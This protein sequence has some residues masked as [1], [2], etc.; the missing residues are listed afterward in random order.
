MMGSNKYIFNVCVYMDLVRDGVVTHLVRCL[1]CKDV[2][3]SLDCQHPLRVLY[4]Q[5][6]GDRDRMVPG[7]LYQKIR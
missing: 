5:Y 4:S 7:P 6:W 1:L 2:N 3:L